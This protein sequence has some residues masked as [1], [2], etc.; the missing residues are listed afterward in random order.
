MET[1]ED[2]DFA[3]HYHPGKANVVADALNRKSYGKLSSLGLR[4][5][6]MH[7]D[8]EDFK[9]CLGWEGQGPCL[10]S[11]SA[12]PMF[13]QRIVEAQVH[14]EFLEKVKAQLVEGEVDENWS[15]HVYGSV[16]F[17]G[18]LCMLKDVELRNELL[19]DAHRAKYTIH[20]KNTKMYQDLK[21]QF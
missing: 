16:R 4:K 8:I 5:F 12:R 14:D 19:A 18:R 1:L 21:R 7:A 13:I 15:M 20:P 3:L 10:Y 9:L 17:R 2:Y 6:E 11:I